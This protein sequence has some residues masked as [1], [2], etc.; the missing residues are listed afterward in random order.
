MLKQFHRVF[1]R[2]L[3]F[4]WGLHLKACGISVQPRSEPWPPAVKVWSLTLQTAKEIPI[5][6]FS[7]ALHNW[8]S[9]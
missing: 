5:V 6:F 1:L 7:I 3:V 8:K 4:F 9:I 2:D